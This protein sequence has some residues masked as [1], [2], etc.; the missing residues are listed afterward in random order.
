MTS[1]AAAITPAI[2][3]AVV[4]SACF[5][6][7][8]VLQ[9]RAVRLAIGRPTLDLR[10]A[11]EQQHHRLGLTHLAALVK[12]RAWLGGFALI[13]LGGSL[14]IVALILAPVS[15]IQPIGVLGLPIA[16]LASAAL[17]RRRPDL[18]LAVPIAACVGSVA[19]F[20]WLSSAQQDRALSTVGDLLLTEVVVMAL[21]A[22]FAFAARHL[23][24]WARCVSSAV[25][26]AVGLGLVSALVRGLAQL[27][28]PG[29]T[30]L[31]SAVGLIMVVGLIA[32]GLLGGWL[33]QRAYA[34]GPP[35]VVIACLTVVDPMVAVLIGFSVLGEGGDLGTSVRAAMIG[36][37]LLAIAGVVALARY[38]PEAVHR[39]TGSARTPFRPIRGRTR[40]EGADLGEQPRTLVSADR[41]ARRVSLGSGKEQP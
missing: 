23:G 30:A 10:P 33:V 5:G 8:A 6:L 11:H 31:I 19:A 28:A 3:L 26:G 18:V 14:H 1:P 27:L 41:P 39:R 32:A 36:C 9:H 29:W 20:V 22:A 38:H 21:L 4:D 17:A 25:A 7:A 2:C 13:L 37:G 16:V 15:L 40:P 34:S 35:E 12:G 24:G